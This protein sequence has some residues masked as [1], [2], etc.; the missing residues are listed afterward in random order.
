MR[1]AEGR[2]GEGSAHCSTSSAN[3]GS[4]SPSETSFCRAT[5]AGKTSGRKTPSESRRLRGRIRRRAGGDRTLDGSSPES[6]KQSV[7]EVRTLTGD[8]RAGFMADLTVLTHAEGTGRIEEPTLATLVAL[9]GKVP[10]VVKQRAAALRHAQRREWLAETGGSNRRTR[11]SSSAN[12]IYEGIRGGSAQGMRIVCCL[13]AIQAH[14]DKGRQQ[15]HFT[16][17]VVA[18][19]AEL[20]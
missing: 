3:E 12:G 15:G 1:T 19:M 10:A 4:H 8:E 5:A 14:A 6:F 13:W 17:R 20:G 7:A 18:V 2:G 9:D 11:E 16:L